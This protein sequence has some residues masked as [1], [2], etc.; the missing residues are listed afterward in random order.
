MRARL[1]NGSKARGVALVLVLVAEKEAVAA[2]V[3][4][5]AGVVWGRMMDRPKRWS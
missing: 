4:A 2:M 3:R 1:L 5:L